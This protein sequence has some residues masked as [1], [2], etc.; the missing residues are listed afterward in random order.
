[1]LGPT[2]FST[3]LIGL[4]LMGLSGTAGANADGDR[5]ANVIKPVERTSRIKPAAIDTE[6]FELGA[7]L[8]FLSVE[9]FNTNRVAG[10]SLN[11]H[12]S[13]Q[14]LAQINYGQSTVERATFEEVA[15]GNFLSNRD[16]EFNYQSLS[17]GYNL[18]H[19]R[20]FLG[21]QRKFNS[22]VYLMAGA[23]QVSFA[24]Q[25][26]T[27]LVLGVNYKT[28]VTDWLTVN[29]D[30]RDLIVDR[31]FLGNRKTTHNTEL[32]LGVSALF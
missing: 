7:Y 32:S 1:M 17:A 26:N 24:G 4:G 11:Y 3:C 6:K 18:L 21:A 29:L 15:E 19:G 10:L 30:F 22:H 25:D 16:R 8:G 2:Y 9:D 12:I 13:V 27:G 23:A 31:E 14:F 20:S 28:V 5:N